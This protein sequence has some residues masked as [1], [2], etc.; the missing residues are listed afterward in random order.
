MQNDPADQEQ[1]AIV[2]KTGKTSVPQSAVDPRR[3]VQP[4]TSVSAH[5]H[6]R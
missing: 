6:H 1:S 4:P 2:I 3:L 5:Q